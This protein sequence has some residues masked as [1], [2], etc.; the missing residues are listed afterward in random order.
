[1]K[2]SKCSYETYQGKFCQNCGSEFKIPTYIT[3]MTV[4]NLLLV[5]ITGIL[6]LSGYAICK[7]YL[8]K[9]DLVNYQKCL[10]VLKIVNICGLVLGVILNIIY[11][12]LKS[13]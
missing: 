8:K 11:I 9:G 10:E 7:T 13:I 2:C 1:M 6:C 4:I 3:V 12:C 5:W